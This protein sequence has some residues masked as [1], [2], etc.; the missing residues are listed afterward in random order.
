MNLSH[1][2]SSRILS[3]SNLRAFS[4]LRGEKLDIGLPVRTSD[5]FRQSFQLSG[6]FFSKKAENIDFGQ[7]V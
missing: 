1:I 3:C 5:L 2:R 6:K 4:S 7:E